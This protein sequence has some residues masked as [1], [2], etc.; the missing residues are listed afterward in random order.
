MY[1]R[2]HALIYDPALHVEVW[3]IFGCIAQLSTPKE[4]SDSRTGTGGQATPTEATIAAEVVGSSSPKRCHPGGS[5]CFDSI[6]GR[7]LQCSYGR[8]HSSL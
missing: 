7:C 3:D 4:Y 1:Q 2:E 5:V 6:G 8:Y